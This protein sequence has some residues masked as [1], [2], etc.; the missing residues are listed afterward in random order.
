MGE[1]VTA[2]G[3]GSLGKGGIKQKGKREPGE[4][5][6]SHQRGEELWG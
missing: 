3:G 5:T 1:Q 2:S 4:Q 6:D